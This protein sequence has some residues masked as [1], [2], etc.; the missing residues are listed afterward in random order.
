MLASRGISSSG[1]HAV[2]PGILTLGRRGQAGWKEHGAF[3]DRLSD[4]GKV[5]LGG[6]GG[7]VDGQHVVPLRQAGSEAEARVLFA[8]DLGQTAS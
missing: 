2:R 1:K 6:P 4:D 3:I 8:D 7:E 5:P